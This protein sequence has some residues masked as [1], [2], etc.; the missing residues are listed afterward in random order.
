MINRSFISPIRVPIIL[1]L[2]VVFCYTQVQGQGFQKTYDTDTTLTTSL[3]N[4]QHVTTKDDGLVVLT[5]FEAGSL[6]TKFDQQGNQL[7][8]KLISVQRINDLALAP[9]GGYVFT[10]TLKFSN[11]STDQLLF[12][13]DPQGNQVWK[14][15]YNFRNNAFMQ[16]EEGLF[17]EHYTSAMASAGNVEAGWYLVGQHS[18]TDNSSQYNKRRDIHMFLTDLKGNLQY[19]NAKP[20][21]NTFFLS[22]P[23]D[24]LQGLFLESSGVA[25]VY[26]T[27][28]SDTGSNMFT[29]SETANRQVESKGY[30]LKGQQIPK[31]IAEIGHQLYVS[32]THQ[33]N[34]GT[35]QFVM[36][37]PTYLSNKAGGQ[38]LKVYKHSADQSNTGI[39]RTPGDR[40]L[41]SG[42]NHLQV[43]TNLNFQWA[44][45]YYNGPKTETNTV[46]FTQD[47][48]YAAGKTG[49]P[50]S[51]DQYLLKSPLDGKVG[52]KDTSLQ[53]ITNTLNVIETNFFPTWNGSLDPEWDSTFSL[54]IQDTSLT[55]TNICPKVPPKA[56]FAIEDTAIC[57]QDCIQP[58]DT[59][60][61][62]QTWTWR[63]MEEESMV[64]NQQEP[65][66][67][68]QD[69]GLKTVIQVV[70]N[71]F[72][73]DTAKQVIQV[74]PIPTGS[75]KPD[76]TI[77][78]GDPV[79]LQATGG[80]KYEWQPALPD[81]EDPQ[82][83]PGQT[84]TY[85]ATI[86]NKF[87]CTAQD[88]ATVQVLQQ[89]TN[90]APLDTTICAF[91]TITFN[92]QN[93]G[94]NYLWSTGDET[95]TI[96]VG[97]AGQYEVEISNKCFNRSKTFTLQT[98]DCTTEY[99]I[100]NAFS[101]NGDGINDQFG[102]KGE[103]I[104]EVTLQ[105]FNRWGQRLYKET[106][107]NPRW[108]GKVNG[109]TV[110]EGAYLY[111]FDIQGQ[112]RGRFFEKGLLN[113]IR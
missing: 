56:G 98:L 52:C 36:P 63:V 103:F 79:Q 81:K 22:D 64:A 104:D 42:N 13:L 2:M 24:S 40:L 108:D 93:P 90:L 68:L 39:H 62:A 86:T 102:L 43:D 85:T 33:D 73:K 21:V 26:G 20:Y 28:A 89:P 107:E 44:R 12:K 74:N 49:Q 37:I 1:W 60:Q 78:E 71:S 59:S 83:T 110:S 4:N 47:H 80:S 50:S 19:T 99:Y 66:F 18:I 51:P 94:F 31:G 106:S 77:C 38:S 10:G 111:R 82:V 8:S 97:Q 23:A 35:H 46:S 92:A 45:Q 27:T 72:G 17:L 70:S 15:N 112:Y 16:N 41:L 87:G 55:K 48:F 61:F 54:P 32:G 7:W 84:T 30:E 5:N 96:T 105:I 91:Q 53:L 9:D 109:S 76:T 29:Y 113:V 34:N 69:T 6:V 11:G 25:T 88:S 3:L 67:C 100:P 14:R 57:I 58:E 95:Q 101:P 65:E 75:V